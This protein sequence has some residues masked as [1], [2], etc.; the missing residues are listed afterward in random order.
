[1]LHSA[2]NKFCL[3]WGEDRSSLQ[4][5]GIAKPLEMMVEQHREGGGGAL[6]L[7]N[8]FLKLSNHIDEEEAIKTKTRE[9]R[10][11]IKMTINVK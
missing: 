2:P 1:M 5:H 10:K 4:L 3:F 11:K 6:T 8:S 9:E 7:I